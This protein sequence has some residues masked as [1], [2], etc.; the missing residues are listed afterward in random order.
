MFFFF[1]LII[2]AIGLLNIFKP[3]FA[4]YLKEGWKVSGGS[5][6]SDTYL[7]LTRFGGVF[8]IILGLFV[9]IS[10]CSM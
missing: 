4:W 5:E 3:S 6:P 8:S 9:M 1:G 7:A 10:G 2:I